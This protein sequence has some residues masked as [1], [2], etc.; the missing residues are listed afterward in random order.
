[1]QVR[2]R[3]LRSL[4]CQANSAH[5][6]PLPLRHRA[7]VLVLGVGQHH[8]S[9]MEK[10][11]PSNRHYGFARFTANLNLT[12]TATQRRGR[13]VVVVGATQ[14][15][16]GCS[17]LTAPIT[18]LESAVHEAGRVPGAPYAASWWH[19]ARFNQLAAWIAR[20]AGAL[21]LD[22]SEV[23]MTR[24]DGA[25]GRYSSVRHDCVHYCMPGVVDTL[26]HHLFNLLDANVVE[27]EQDGEGAVDVSTRRFFHM[28]ANWLKIRGIAAALERR[29]DACSKGKCALN[30]LEDEWWWSA[31]EKTVCGTKEQRV[32]A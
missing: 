5:V 30:R 32:I 4:L 14:P 23:S 26:S 18:L 6:P 15:V 20:D 31:L 24:G 7:D 17:G 16:P 8:A 13:R 11:L 25:M 12:L 1:M 19:N 22:T 28:G 29:G 3:A 27:E 21:F 9:Q 2:A 10:M